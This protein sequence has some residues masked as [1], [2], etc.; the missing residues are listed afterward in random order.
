VLLFVASLCLFPFLGTAFIPEM[1]EGTL[2][3]NAD[4]VP[5]ISLDESIKME[6]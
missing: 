5:Y 1:Q 4:R 3:P 2:G 6:F